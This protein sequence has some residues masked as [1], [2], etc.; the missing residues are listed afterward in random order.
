ME[1]TTRATGEPV[2]KLPVE[3]TLGGREAAGVTRADG[4]VDLSVVAAQ[5]GPQPLVVTV[6]L[7]PTDRLLVRRPTRGPRVP[8]GRGGSQ[9]EP[10]ACAGR[11]RSGPARPWR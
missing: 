9:G 10:H 5:P 11:C 8:R 6:R 3:V 7:L 1:V 4:S 2:R